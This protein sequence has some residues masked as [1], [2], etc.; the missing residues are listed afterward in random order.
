MFHTLTNTDTKPLVAGL[1]LPPTR[2]TDG[3]RCR[4]LAFVNERI[5][6]TPAPENPGRPEAGVEGGSP[7]VRKARQ[8]TRTRAVE[9]ALRPRRPEINEEEEQILRAATLHLIQKHGM[10][11]VATGTREVQIKG[12]RVWIIT[13]TLRYAA[14][15]EGYI[16]DLLYDGEQFT[17]LTEQSVMDQ[18]AQEIAE[19]PE[20]LRKWDEY[21]ASTLHPGEE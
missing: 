8:G 2:L 11:L 15:H 20:E 16:G 9:A 12:F 6:K 21:R 7:V 1:E 13:M 17:F 3:T 10:F 4:I 14:G 18:R 19:D 5:R